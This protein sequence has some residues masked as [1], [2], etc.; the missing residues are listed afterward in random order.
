MKRTF[1]GRSRLAKRVRSARTSV[2]I[3]AV[4]RSMGFRRRAVIPS[5][6]RSRTRFAEIKSVDVVGSSPNFSTQ[7]AFILLNGVQEG[8]GF[9]NRVGRK[10]A[11]RSLYITGFVKPTL[12]NTGALV[13]DWNRLLIFYDRQSN[14]APPTLSDVL[15]DYDNAGA[16]T[17]TALSQINMNNRDRFLILKDE[18]IVTPAIGIS[19]AAATTNTFAQYDLEDPAVRIKTFLKLKNLETHYKASSNPAV[20]GD[21]AT[22][23]LFLMVVALNGSFASPAWTFQFESRMKYHDA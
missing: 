19:G 23:A 7:G 20:I 15:T 18:R 3:A 12:S 8:S 11:M 2:S 14:G 10:V 16:T 5:A 4:R 21:I 13:Q 6:L 1:G 9:Y 22:G 17:T